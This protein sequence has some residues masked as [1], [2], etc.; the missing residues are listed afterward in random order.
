MSKLTVAVVVA[1]VVV[2]AV[3]S[4][5][6]VGPQAAITC[7][8]G[9]VDI[10]P[11]QSI[12]LVVTA[13]AAN[14]TFC[15][16]AGTHQMTSAITPKTGDIF[17]G[18]YGAVLDGSTWSTTDDTQGAFRALN[19]DID[20]VTIRNLVIRNMPQK[21]ITAF[22]DYADHWTIENT[23]LA[24]NKYGVEVAP[25][26][27]V[28]NNFIHHNISSTPDAVSPS[29]RGGGYIGQYADRC[30]IEGNEI[31]YNGSEQKILHSTGVVV[32]NNFV[33]H[34]RKDGIWFDTN[35]TS[36]AIVDGN[37]VEDNGRDGISIEA[38]NGATVRNNTLRRNQEGL[39]IYRSQNTQLYGNVL[40]ANGIAM[41]YYVTCD[42]L[43]GEDLANNSAHDNTI[44]VPVDGYANGF[45]SSICTA[46]QLI[47]YLTDQR[48]NDYDRNSYTVPSSTGAY[49]LWGSAKTWAQWQAI[50]QDAAGCLT[51]SAAPPSSTPPPTD[52]PPADTLP[53]T[54]TLSATRSG[55]SSNYSVKASATDN[56]AVTWFQ[57]SLDGSVF[58][59][60]P[61]TCA[62]GCSMK[63]TKPGSHL[64]KA[65][66]KDAAG[67]YASTTQNVTR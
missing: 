16:R 26:C 67:N 20:Y 46:D 22:H 63:I 37:R 48:K 49:W 6:T 40:E 54:V 4:A 66:A 36:T 58:A 31:A 13:N 29:A 11:G 32:R 25:D 12:P 9:A 30:V 35:Y 2:A 57:L 38:T 62:S 64:F 43:P 53:P 14:T 27:L 41:Q 59:S 23:E 42:G 60:S 1:L 33:H 44:T 39:L 52:P 5:Q 3:A 45:M 7:P 55:N 50:P 34:N 8:A 24:F 56:V 28:R 61:A 47:P 65:E 17:V 21:A 15:L 51:C 18:E 19:Q 10:Y